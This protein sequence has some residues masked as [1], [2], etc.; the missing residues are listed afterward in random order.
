MY[1]SHVLCKVD[2]LRAAVTG[3]QDAGFTVQLGDTS[4]KAIN[5]LIWF[6]QGPFLELIHAKRARPPAMFGWVMRHVLR[7]RWVD[8]FD[9]WVDQDE[10]W[11]ELALETE[12]SIRPELERLRDHQIRCFGPVRN[13]RTPP[14]SVTITTQ[15]AFPQLVALPILM[16][17]YQPDPR[18]SPITHANGA[19]GVRTIRVQVPEERLPLWEH[20]T[21]EREHWLRIEP[22]TAYRVEEVTLEGLRAPIEPA[23]INGARLSPA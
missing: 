23:R 17:A 13:R 8:R 5:A 19:T 11:C 6:Q 14:D 21:D 22:G 16:G 15:T 1:S 18:P 2:D 12:G 4:D 10:G 7:Q 9:A 3:W 20:L